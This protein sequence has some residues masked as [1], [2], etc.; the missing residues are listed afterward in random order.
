MNKVEFF[1]KV[2]LL[3]RPRTYLVMLQKSKPIHYSTVKTI[4]NISK[5]ELTTSEKSVLNKGLNI[6]TTIKL[7][8]YLDLI[9][10]IEDAALKI[11]KAWADVLRW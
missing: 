6:A 9:A 2:V 5:Q 7:I 1:L 10:P 3:V 11:P 8:P 4:V